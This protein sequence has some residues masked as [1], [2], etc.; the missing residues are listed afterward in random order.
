MEKYL[1]GK[2]IKLVKFSDQYIIGKYL[3]WLNDTQIN[4][5]I[6]SRRFP[7]VRG[8]VFVPNGEKNLMFSILSNVGINSGDSLWQ[9]DDFNHFIGTCS[10]HNIDW[11]NRKAEIGYMIGE[12]LYWGTGMATETVS[13]L[14]DYAFNKLNLNKL[15]AHV[16]ANNQASCKVLLKNGYKQYATEEQDFYLE[17][18]Y[19]DSYRFHNF[20]EWRNNGSIS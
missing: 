11:I 1:E 20:A 17:G 15:N 12:K 13:L 3:N 7:V 19:L 8:D 4:K 18:K 2:K 16:V 6:D 14:T 9:D 5:Y 10:I